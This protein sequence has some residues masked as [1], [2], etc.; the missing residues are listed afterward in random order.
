MRENDISGKMRNHFLKVQVITRCREA[1]QAFMKLFKKLDLPHKLVQELSIFP[2]KAFQKDQIS[3][4]FLDA[5]KF[6]DVSAV[7]E[8]LIK[9]RFLVFEYDDCHNT[10]MHWSCKRNDLLMTKLLI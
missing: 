5:V 8:M 7:A 4:D 3:R 1:I 6:G 9:D 10:A 2:Y